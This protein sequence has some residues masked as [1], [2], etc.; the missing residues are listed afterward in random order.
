DS[1]LDSGRD[2][3]A[4]SGGDSGADADFDAGPIGEA[5]WVPLPGLPDGCVIE[6]AEHPEVLFAPEWLSCGDGCQYLAPE[7]RFQRAYDRE[8]WHDGSRWWFAVVQSSDAEH[9]EVVLASSDGAAVAAWRSPD[10]WED[11]LCIVGPSAIADGAAAV[12]VKI[13][14]EDVQQFRLYHAPLD[15]IGSVTEPTAVRDPSMGVGS[16][17][18][19]N[20]SVSRTTVAAE[21]QPAG[22]VIVFE[23][24]RSRVLGGVAS[25]TPATPQRVRVVGRDVWWEDWG[26]PTSLV[27]GSIDREGR[28]LRRNVPD[29][30]FVL[31]IDDGQMAWLQGYGW[32]GAGV[33]YERLELWMASYTDEPT[34]L[35]PQRIREV[36]TWGAALLGEGVYGF[37]TADFDGANHRTELYDIVDGRRRTYRAPSGVAVPGSPLGISAAEMLFLGRY[38]RNPTLFRIDITRLPYEE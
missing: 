28:Y 27:V 24:G 29:D 22:V 35:R 17:G 18:V 6:R 21:V 16:T 14:L 7:P 2:T 26:H 31:G 11:G 36:E 9:R 5:G 37:T 34:E 13:W 30:A 8:G 33:Q 1:G 23:A 3:S 38:E 32:G 25:P 10:G 15:V 19:Q 4:D 12:G 20:L